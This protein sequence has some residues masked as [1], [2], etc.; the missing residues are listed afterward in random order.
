MVG[1]IQEQLSLAELTRREVERYVGHSDESNLHFLS[2]DKQQSYA[3]VDVPHMPRTYSPEIVVM[4]HVVGDFIIIDEDTT[5]KSLFEA[6][7]I[8]AHI[9]R[10][11]IILAYHGESLPV[12]VS[13]TS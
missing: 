1:I 5:D 7:M 4:A 11:K 13:K 10:E 3:V 6:L 12:E 8:N 2:D 9:P